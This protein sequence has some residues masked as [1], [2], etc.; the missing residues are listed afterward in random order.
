[1]DELN[2]SRAAVVV[3]CLLVSLT[4]ASAQSLDFTTNTYTVGA[5]P[6]WVAAADLIGDGSVDLVCANYGT[7]TLT[8]LTNNG[9][10][11]FHL[12]GTL[13]VGNGPAC[14]VAADV[15]GDGKVDL[16]SANSATNT[17][18]VW[19]NKGNAAFALKGTLTVGYG[20]TSLAAADINGDG[21]IDLISANSWDNTLTVLTNNGSGGFESSATLSTHGVQPTSVVVA[22]ING[23]GK[24]DLVVANFSSGHTGSLVVLTNNGSG[25]FS[26]Y[27]SILYSSINRPAPNCVVAA[28]VNGDGQMDLISASP[29][30]ASTILVWTNTSGGNFGLDFAG[31]PSSYYPFCVTAADIDGDGSVDLIV[32]NEGNS[33]TW[34]HTLTLLTNNGSG[35]F[36][37]NATLNVGNGPN[38]VIAADVNGDGHPDLISANY[39]TNTITVLTRVIPV[40]PSLTVTPTSATHVSLSW[41]S[42]AVGFV[43]QTNT[44]LATTNWG[45]A[46]STVSTN[47]SNES[48]TLTMPSAGKLFIRMVHP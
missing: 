1:M 16:I 24:P 14:V 33:P 32:A 6:C 26:L 47:G 35:G 23:D 39:G 7:N 17:L 9:S 30:S 25:G 29:T 22:D 31:T 15:N 8:I 3:C 21:Y 5:N 44:D 38:C 13:T 43:L 42:Q 46:T 28:D 36:G 2:C 45:R 12:K 48:T 40:T 4:L 37:S 10:G 41:T 27:L 19:T 20:P 11:V 18:T 34:G